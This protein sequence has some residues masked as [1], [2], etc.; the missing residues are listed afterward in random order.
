MSRPDALDR[1]AMESNGS[2]G[3]RHVADTTVQSDLAQLSALSGTLDDLTRRVTEIAGRYTETT[4]EDFA[5]GLYEVE[6]SLVSAGRRLE[7]VRRA[8]R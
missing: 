6:R 8:Q 2:A 1:G 7:R 4:R 3:K 5:V